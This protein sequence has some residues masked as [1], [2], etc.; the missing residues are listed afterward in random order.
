VNR[1]EDVIWVL[2]PDGKWSRFGK[3]PRPL[4]GPAA[5]IIDGRLVVAGGAPRGF[6]PQ[7]AVWAQTLSQ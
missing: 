6:D 3:L 4:I 5:R 7:S 2:S 1:V